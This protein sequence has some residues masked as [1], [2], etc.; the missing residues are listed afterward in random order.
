VLRERVTL[1][2]AAGLASALAA[3]AVLAGS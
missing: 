1:R 2:K 3:L